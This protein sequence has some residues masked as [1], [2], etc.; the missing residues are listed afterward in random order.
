MTDY[1]NKYN[2]WFLGFQVVDQKVLQVF[3]VDQKHILHIRT[4]QVQ[5]R[6]LNHW[7][8]L[9]STKTKTWSKHGSEFSG[10]ASKRHSIFGL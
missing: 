4:D 3:V 2:V 5:D 1:T 9:C 6:S 8:E 10:L 7:R